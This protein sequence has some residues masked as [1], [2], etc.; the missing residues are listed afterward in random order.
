MMPQQ[1]PA[2]RLKTLFTAIDTI[3]SGCRFPLWSDKE[4]PT[5]KYCGEKRKDESS[6]CPDHH[7]R[8]LVRVGKG[9]VTA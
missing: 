2:P 8:C 7:A 9:V 3:T 4:L 6:Y 1:N 5:H